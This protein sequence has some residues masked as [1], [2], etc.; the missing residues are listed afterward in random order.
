MRD[1]SGLLK[2]SGSFLAAAASIMARRLHY[3]MTVAG[4]RA[5]GGQA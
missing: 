3:A 4:Y 2:T 5:V 1:R